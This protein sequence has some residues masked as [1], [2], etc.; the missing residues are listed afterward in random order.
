[1]DINFI[2]HEYN[3]KFGI[4][5]LA[6]FENTA[7]DFTR[8]SIS[9]IYADNI[10][11]YL[12]GSFKNPIRF[13]Q[14]S[15]D[16]T[17]IDVY[18]FKEHLFRDVSYLERLAGNGIYFADSEKSLNFKE[19]FEFMLTVFED[20]RQV[21]EYYLNE[22]L[23]L[24]CT[25]EIYKSL[26]RLIYANNV[27]FLEKFPKSILSG[28]NDAFGKKTFLDNSSFIDFVNVF[29]RHCL[30][31]DSSEHN[32]SYD[33]PDDI[34]SIIFNMREQLISKASDTKYRIYD[35]NDARILD[36]VIYTLIEK[37]YFLKHL[38]KLEVENG[39]KN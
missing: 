35:D 17:L 34:R 3:K 4:T 38:R 5:I 8:T 29:V 23:D 13:T 37:S 27:M 25:L 30:Q 10:K 7:K 22:P 15:A 12:K 18:D 39:E 32:L 2:V 19:L 33:V 16:V 31:C 9:M 26:Y 21:A 24:S 11:S 20:E 28:L 6:V 36:N 1:M 14:G